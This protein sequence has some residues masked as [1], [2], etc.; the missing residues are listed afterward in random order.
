MSTTQTGSHRRNTSRKKNHKKDA[1]KRPLYI[2]IPLMLVMGLVLALIVKTLLFQVFTIPSGSMENTLRIGDRVAVDKLSPLLGR[3]PADGDVIV[4]EDPDHWL[5]GEAGTTTQDYGP[6]KDT[7][8]FFGVIPPASSDHLVK[9]VIATGGQTVKC[10]GQTLTVDGQTVDEP[11]LYP[12]DNS[13]S[14]WG[15]VGPVTVPQGYVWVEGDHR[16]DSADSRF[17]QNDAHQGM[18][19][20]D[21][22]VGPVRAVVWPLGDLNWL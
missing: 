14:G 8:S 1:K 16:S 15:D 20:V 11:Y 19:P 5:A 9:R 18:V 4:F 6:V 22:I 17:H 21:D 12:G 13:C 3:D 10:S 7:L 2:E